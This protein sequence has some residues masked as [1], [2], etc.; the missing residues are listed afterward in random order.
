MVTI[1]EAGPAAI[2]DGW[3]CVNLTQFRECGGGNGEAPVPRPLRRRIVE[4]H[5]LPGPREM[6]VALYPIR[7][8]LPSQIER[9]YRV[10]RRVMRRPAMGYEL[11][12][13]GH[14]VDSTRV[15]SRCNGKDAERK[16]WDRS[17]RNW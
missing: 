10:L 2:R 17:E 14:K 7:A 11:C 3:S 1:A 6:E 5:D 8:L 4:A 12:R 15:R 9:R 16:W 13:H